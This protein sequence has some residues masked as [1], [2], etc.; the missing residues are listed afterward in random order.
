[1][2]VPEVSFSNLTNEQVEQ[3]KSLEEK[4][5]TSSGQETILIAYANPK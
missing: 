4:L 3:V 2:N 5:N 1:M